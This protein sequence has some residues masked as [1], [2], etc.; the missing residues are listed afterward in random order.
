MRC[1]LLVEVHEVSIY[2]FIN[3]KEIE[4][5]DSMSVNNGLKL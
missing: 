5:S 4:S 2:T 1:A 3:I